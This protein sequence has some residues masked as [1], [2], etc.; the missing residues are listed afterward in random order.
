MKPLQL[1]L[2]FDERGAL[3][4]TSNPRHVGVEGWPR[5]TVMS[6][7][8]QLTR[9]VEL[10]ELEGAKLRERLCT[11]VILPEETPPEVA[12]SGKHSFYELILDPELSPNVAFIE[13]D[14]DEAYNFTVWYT[15]QVSVEALRM[16]GVSTLLQVLIEK[17]I[18]ITM[19]MAQEAAK[20]RMSGI[21]IPGR[22]GGVP[23][24]VRLP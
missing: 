17:Y 5:P 8:I 20:K 23:P 18:E 4:F 9:G 12:K 1:V 15:G 11:G 3:V 21:Q 24:N 16:Y 7:A 10:V 22:D 19:L 14:E 6:C 13:E 2:V